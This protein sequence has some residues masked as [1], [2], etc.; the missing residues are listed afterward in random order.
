MSSSMSLTYLTVTLA[1]FEFDSGHLTELVRQNFHLREFIIN[2]LTNSSSCTLHSHLLRNIQHS[3]YL[4]LDWVSVSS[5]ATQRRWSVYNAMVTR[6]LNISPAY[7]RA[8]VSSV[9]TA[10]I[11]S[12]VS[13]SW[14]MVTL[15]AEFFNISAA[16]CTVSIVTWCLISPTCTSRSVCT[17]VSHTCSLVVSTGGLAISSAISTHTG[18]SNPFSASVLLV[19]MS[20][21]SG[22]NR[23]TILGG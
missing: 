6:E 10:I 19:D 7:L 16:T 23:Q 17:P 9:V 5:K 22:K 11:S 21:R 4:G 1:V 12:T 18:F 15:E 3:L 13:P 8:V 14:E 20:S 2:A